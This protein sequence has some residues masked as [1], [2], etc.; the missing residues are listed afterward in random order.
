MKKLLST[1]L[2]ASL[3]PINLASFAAETAQVKINCTNVPLKSA[4]QS[5]YSA[6]RVDYINE[7]QNPVRVNDV[8]FYNN[9]TAVSPYEGVQPPKHMALKALLFLPTLGVTGAML[10]KDLYKRGDEATLNMNEAKRF[11]AF[12]TQD[13]LQT[14][15]EILGQ[16]Q[17]IQFNVLVPLNEKPEL[18]GTFEDTATHKFIRVEGQK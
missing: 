9:I 2:L 13:G 11:N 4:L 16:G 12:Y 5:K 7:G 8:K 18:V 14:H 1:I 3:M 10:T 6:Y 17:S 15:N